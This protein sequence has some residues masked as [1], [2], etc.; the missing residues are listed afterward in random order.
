[1]CTTPRERT[2]GEDV[3]KHIV[4]GTFKTILR[5]YVCM[6]VYISIPANVYIRH[7]MEMFINYTHKNMEK[8]LPNTLLLAPSRQSC[9]CMYIKCM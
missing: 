5:V 7:G 4:A 6:R 8:M 9:E 3:D 1:M 2:S